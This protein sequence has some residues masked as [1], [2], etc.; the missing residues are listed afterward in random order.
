M[1]FDDLQKANIQSMKDHDKVAHE[2]ISLVFG[3]CKNEA[4]DKGCADRKLPDPE[5][6]RIIQKTIKELEEEKLAFEKA[7]RPERVE[8]LKAQMEILNKYLPKQLSEDEIR[9][10]IASLEDKKIPSVMKYF[11]AN[12][13]G[14][15]DNSLVSKIAKEFN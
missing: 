14:Q 12:Y 9:T 1:I 3:K 15:V 7:Q 5:A 2:I 10:I 13:Q 6:L 4:I 8:E 11:K